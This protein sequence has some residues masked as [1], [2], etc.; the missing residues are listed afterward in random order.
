MAWSFSEQNRPHGRTIVRCSPSQTII[1]RICHLVCNVN[2][3]T[4][5]RALEGV[6]IFL[7]KK[8]L[9]KVMSEQGK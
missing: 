7:I 5:N 6:A 2:V 4:F 1:Y 3:G 9:V 8:W